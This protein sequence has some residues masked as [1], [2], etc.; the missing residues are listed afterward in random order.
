MNST[1]AHSQLDILETIPSADESVRRQVWG[2]LAGL[3]PRGHAPERRGVQRFPYPQL[4]YLTPL[5]ADDA[6]CGEP[7]AV[8]GKDLSERGLGFYHAQSLPYR[9]MIASLEMPQGRWAGF[10]ID[11][12]WTRFTHYGW[13][14]SGGKFLQAVPSPIR[15][16]AS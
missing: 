1:F 10:L 13:Y 12:R 6:P 2:V 5:G 14:D 8:I 11:L 9:R 7:I 16:A 3:Y 4:F 15:R